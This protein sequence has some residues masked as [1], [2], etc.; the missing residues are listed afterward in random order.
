M[1]RIGNGTLV[2]HIR[3]LSSSGEVLYVR[4]DVKD[5]LRLGLA[6]GQ[7][8][9]LDVGQARLAG[10]VKTSGGSPWLA[11]MPGNSNPSMTSAM[12]HAGLEHGMDIRAA[13]SYQHHNLDSAQHDTSGDTN[14][15]PSARA[16]QQ[17]RASD[18]KIDSSTA[19]SYVRKYN[20]DFYRGRLNVE[21]DR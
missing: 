21:L 20:T 17:R 5:V 13:I 7:E 14:R 15:V 6:H 16:F 9:E 8:V 18:A 19:A 1:P 12:R 10:I 11:P 3:R 2:A 4:I